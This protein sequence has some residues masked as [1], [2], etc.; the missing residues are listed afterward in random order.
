MEGY[1]FTSLIVEVADGHYHIRG[2]QKERKPHSIPFMRLLRRR[3]AAQDCRTKP[4]KNSEVSWQVTAQDI[5]AANTL[6]QQY[7]QKSSDVP[8]AFRLSQILRGVGFYLDTRR[9][10]ELKCLS[11]ASNRVSFEYQ[12]ASGRTERVENSFEFFYDYWIN[13]YLQR[14]D[15]TVATKRYLKELH[16]LSRPV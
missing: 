9:E 15:R 16:L 14:R 11:I 2:L 12:T 1:S 7:R 8:D 4:P 3:S 10:A 5:S 13:M 6:N